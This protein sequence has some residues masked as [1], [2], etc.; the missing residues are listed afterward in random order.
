MPDI[1]SPDDGSEAVPS[2]GAASRSEGGLPDAQGCAGQ[3]GT[4]G[5][6]P[7]SGSGQRSC[8]D[9][10]PT[11]AKAAC[12]RQ[13]G[14]GQA[15]VS[16][17]EGCPGG[18][19]GIPDTDPGHLRHAE[20]ASAAFSLADPGTGAA[21]VAC[22]GRVGGPAARGWK[23]IALCGAD[24]SERRLPAPG[25]GPQSEPGASRSRPA[26]PPGAGQA[27]SPGRRRAGCSLRTWW[28]RRVSRRRPRPDGWG[29]RRAPGTYARRLPPPGRWWRRSRPSALWARSPGRWTA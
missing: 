26:G 11:R 1:G 14:H 17:D 4:A 20:R 13:G 24:L 6:S 5:R 27:R 22:G 25:P 21:A 12:I 23:R 15:A 10:T 3:P 16:R 19:A 8:G 2:R 18:G 29:A 9:T 7:G 28:A